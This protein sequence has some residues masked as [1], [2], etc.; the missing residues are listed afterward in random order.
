LNEAQHSAWRVNARGIRLMMASMAAYLV[1]DTLVKFAG[2]TVPPAQLIFVR[3]IMA[4]ANFMH[5][6]GAIKAKPSS[7]KDAFIPELH[8]SPGN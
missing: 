7:W 2:Q 5:D 8:S 6:T 1:N 3:G 4:F